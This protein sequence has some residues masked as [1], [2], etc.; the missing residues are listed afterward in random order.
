[1][2]GS[3]TLRPS[4]TPVHD[5]MRELRHLANA[6]I[7]VALC[8]MVIALESTIYFGADRTSGPMQRF[9]EF[10]FGPFTQPQWWR[11]HLTIRKCGHFLG[12]GILSISWFRAF[13][14]T[15]PLSSPQRG[16]RMS[17]HS[18]AMLGTLFVACC[19]ELHQRFLPN[20]SGSFVD[21]MVDCSGALLMQVLTWLWMRK[22]FSI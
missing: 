8:V 15:F 4:P 3:V 2:T 21:V 17:I 19:D 16:S 14:M 18:F 20:R 12:Y 1:M 9:F 6:W 22:R 11:L 5:R 10:F 7:P 13:R